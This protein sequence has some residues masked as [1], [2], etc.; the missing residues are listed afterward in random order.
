MLPWT[1]QLT[2]SLASLFDR[3]IA[4]LPPLRIERKFVESRVILLAVLK[5][6]TSCSCQDS[7]HHQPSFVQPATYCLYPLHNPDS[8]LLVCDS[9]RQQSPTSSEGKKFVTSCWLSSSFLKLKVKEWKWGVWRRGEWI[10]AGNL[11]TNIPPLTEAKV[12][13]RQ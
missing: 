11:S 13:V 10:V 7:S 3:W 9:S 1:L 2:E 4:K 5:W 8:V 12:D 6:R